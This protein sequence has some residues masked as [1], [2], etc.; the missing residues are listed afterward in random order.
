MAHTK[1]PE[2]V[3]S[4]H[5][6]CWRISVAAIAAAGLLTLI[7]FSAGVAAG[8]VPNATWYWTMVVSP[9]DPK[10]LV[11][12]TS[13]GIYRSDDGGKAWS[14][15]GLANV[16]ATSL[17][18][19]GG[20]I[21][22]GGV[23]NPAHASAIVTKKGTYLVTPGPGVL[24]SSRDGG[25]TWNDLHPSGLPNLEIAAL[26][27]DPAKTG[28]LYAVLRNGAV[29][30]STDGGRSFTRVTARIAGTPWALALTQDS[31]LVAGDM[32]N[33]NY[34]STNGSQ[35]HHI[36]SPTPAAATW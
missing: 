28:D 20:T 26:A 29:Y 33:G 25:K 9:S 1:S 27:V 10:V 17:A 15:A 35:W 16:N 12:G 34:L 6:P 30:L 31:H 36:P 7:A 5:P 18:Q 3:E 24:A 14:P 22:A 21:F 32:S 8:A 19:T 2:R 4:E 11:L 23:R 13:S